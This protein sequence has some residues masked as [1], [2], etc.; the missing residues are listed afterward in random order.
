MD[1]ENYE[2]PRDRLKLGLLEDELAKMEDSHDGGGVSVAN[3]LSF[4]RNLLWAE[5]HQMNIDIRMFDIGAKRR[6]ACSTI[7][8]RSCVTVSLSLG[9]LHVCQFPTS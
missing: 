6:G 1:I 8:T 9:A 7:L 3:Y 5:E 2:I 4:Y